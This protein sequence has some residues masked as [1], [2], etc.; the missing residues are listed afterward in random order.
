[1]NQSKFPSMLSKVIRKG[2]K[3]LTFFFFIF[4]DSFHPIE[5]CAIYSLPCQF[6]LLKISLYT[7]PTS[8]AEV[9]SL[10]Y[11]ELAEE[12]VENATFET[13]C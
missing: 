13:S 6:F 9:F 11:L 5:F 3:Q 7:T 1:M 10:L 8:F 12:E 4:H 2:Q